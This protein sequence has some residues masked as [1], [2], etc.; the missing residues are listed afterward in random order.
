[1]RYG[2]KNEYRVSMEIGGEGINKFLLNQTSTCFD[3]ANKV[4]N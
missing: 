3:E 4:K 1:M 2:K